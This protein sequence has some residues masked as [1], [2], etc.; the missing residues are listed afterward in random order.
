M[1]LSMREHADWNK[2]L[3]IMRRKSGWLQLKASENPHTVEG[4]PQEELFTEA[5]ADMEARLIRAIE[6]GEMGKYRQAAEKLSTF[7]TPAH[8]GGT[9]G[10]GAYRG[11]SV[12]VRA[13]ELA[14]LAAI[15]LIRLI[16]LEA[17]EQGELVGWWAARGAAFSTT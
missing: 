14:R 10:Q 9:G 2:R 8:G 6:D 3:E 17:R 7:L 5:R 16:V 11:V 15:Q 4:P 1:G 12:E 13:P